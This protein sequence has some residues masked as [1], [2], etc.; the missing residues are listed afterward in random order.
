MPSAHM[1]RCTY[2]TSQNIENPIEFNAADCWSSLEIAFFWYF[3]IWEKVFDYSKSV[4][5]VLLQ[6]KMGT[7]ECKQLVLTYGF[8]ILESFILQS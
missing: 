7:Q 5:R 6:V 4:C 3:I 1:H 8:H 2:L